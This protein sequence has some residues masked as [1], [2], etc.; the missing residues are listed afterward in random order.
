MAGVVPILRGEYLN[1]MSNNRPISVNPVFGKVFERAVFNRLSHYLE[2]L[3]CL[4][5]MSKGFEPINLLQTQVWITRKLFTETWILAVLLFIIF[6]FIKAS[7]CIKHS[8]LLAKL[9][10]SGIRAVAK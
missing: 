3:I 9:D 8:I 10:S 6:G 1:E 4:S 7:D 5:K 2:N